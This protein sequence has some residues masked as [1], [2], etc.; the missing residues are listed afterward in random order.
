[1]KSFKV[2][3]V[4]AAMAISLAGPAR[5]AV[6]PPYAE[7]IVIVASA[8][9]KAALEM[10]V[11]QLFDAFGLQLGSF[12]KRKISALKTLTSQVA[13]ASKAKINADV[14]LVQGEMGAVGVLEQARQQLRVYQDFS[15]ATGQGIDPCSQMAAQTNMAVASGQAS[16]LAA[17]AIASLASGP[18]R[19]GNPEVYAEMLLRQRA[20]NFATADEAKLGYGIAATAEVLTAT[21]EKFPMSGADTNAR[22]LLADSN[23]PMMQRAKQAFLSYMAGPPDRAIPSDVAALPS[24][25]EYLA[26]KRRKDA[27]MSIGMN[28]LARISAEN[29]PNPEIGGKSK[30][31]AMNEVVGLYY[32]E[33]SQP[34]ARGWASQ[35]DR[36]LMVDQV[37]LAAAT[38]GVEAELL[39][40]SHRKEAILAGLLALEAM[41][42]S[43]DSLA[44]STGSFERER[45]RPGIR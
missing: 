12:A 14:A 23:D 30:M 5:A 1:M 4:I 33:A 8:A 21:G 34:R 9:M 6:C 40:Q 15:V 18:G 10:I 28:S 20:Q 17:E 37:K 11:S 22:V 42:E 35:S 26:L 27:A 24:G 29:T 19:Y 41:R 44:A 3:I 13:T 2:N 45:S 32:G 7:T 25:K 39:E 31:A 43:S 16:S 38:L 36:G